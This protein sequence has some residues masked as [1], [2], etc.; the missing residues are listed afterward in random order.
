MAI[1]ITNRKGKQSIRATGKDAQVLFDAMCRTVEVQATTK[2][3]ANAS[4]PVPNR[5][6]EESQGDGAARPDS[7]SVTAEGK[8]P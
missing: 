2:P 5:P 4:N 6:K 3:L 8:A 7:A 1:T